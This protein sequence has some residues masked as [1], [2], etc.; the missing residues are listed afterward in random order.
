M[1]INTIT[2]KVKNALRITTDK[3]SIKDE[4]ND[5]V[6]ACI[7]DLK[8]SGVVINFDDP[9]LIQVCKIYAKAFFGYDDKSEKFKNIYFEMKKDMA[10]RGAYFNG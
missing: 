6:T 10:V 7:E 3:E 5:V 9:L 8:R 2:E 1:D 4:I